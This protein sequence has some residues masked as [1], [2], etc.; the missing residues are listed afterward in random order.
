MLSVGVE[1][2]NCGKVEVEDVIIINSDGVE[3]GERAGQENRPFKFVR[4]QIK[5]VEDLQIDKI[6]LLDRLGIKRSIARRKHGYN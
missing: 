6:R 1:L 4:L 5:D 2:K 3:G